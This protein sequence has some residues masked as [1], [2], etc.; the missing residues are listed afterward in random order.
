MPDTPVGASCFVTG[1]GST[2]MKLT[3]D[4]SPINKFVPILQQAVLQLGDP[5][6]CA[7]EF[8]YGSITPEMMCAS[9]AGK[10]TCVHSLYISLTNTFLTVIPSA[11]L[12]VKAT[13]EA[14]WYVESHCLNRPSGSLLEAHRLESMAKPFQVPG[15]W[16]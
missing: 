8:R 10:D 14:R 1:F 11:I 4:Q 9:S 15:N 2:L 7:V 6:D 16:L 5:L 3:G 12:G 13:V